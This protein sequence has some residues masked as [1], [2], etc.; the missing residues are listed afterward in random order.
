MDPFFDMVYYGDEK[1]ST[2]LWWGVA[3]LFGAD[4]AR[5]STLLLFIFLE[6]SYEKLVSF[7]FRN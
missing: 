3:E 7:E 2:Y 5:S 1:L 6:F 4:R